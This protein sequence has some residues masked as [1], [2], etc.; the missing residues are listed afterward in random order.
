MMESVVIRIGRSRTR[1]AS[2]M[3]SRTE[4]PRGTQAI[5]V[6]HLQDPVLL[7]DAQQQEHSQSAP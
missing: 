2:M 5:G 1:L 6:I 4:C 3:A 7:H